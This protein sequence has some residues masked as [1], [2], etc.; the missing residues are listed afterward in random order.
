MWAVEQFKWKRCVWNKQISAYGVACHIQGLPGLTRTDMH[1][2]FIGLTKLCS[3]VE[4]RKLSFLEK[5]ISLPNDSRAKEIFYLVCST[6]HLFQV[7]ALDLYQT[8]GS[9][10]KNILYLKHS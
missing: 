2:S 7:K 10:L 1:E 5:L 9:Y 6:T 4:I 8:L 3:E